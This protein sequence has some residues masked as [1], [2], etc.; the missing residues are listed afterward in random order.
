MTIFLTP[1]EKRSLRRMLRAVEVDR[2]GFWLSVLLGVVGMGSSIALAA[3]SAWLIAR[4]SQLPPVLYLSVAATSVRMFGVLRALMRYLQRLA[5]HKVALKGMDSLRF[6]VYSSLADARVDRVASM[7]RGDL[8]ARTGADIDAVGD[9]V[10]KAILPAMITG[11]VS[12]GTVGGIALISPATG[13][14]LAV[15]LIA[16]GI[17]APLVTMR[18][19]RLA[20]TNARDARVQ[21]SGGVVS[22]LEGASELG[23]NGRLD[24]VKRDI[25]AAETAIISST[26]KAARVSAIAVFVDRFAMGAA[27]VGAML[28][29]IPHTY[30]GTI[31]A[32]LLAVIVLTPL[33]SFEGTAEMAPA[34]VQLV[35]SA[36]ASERIDALLGNDAPL[37]EHP[38]PVVARPRLEARNL[39][40]G[41]PGG[42]I[43]ARNI[44]LDFTVG[45]RLA[46]VGPSGV[47][48]TTLLLTLAGM[49]EPREGSVTLNGVDIWAG[50]RDQVTSQV[51]MTAEDAHVFA[52]TVLENMRVAHPDLDEG[53]AADLLRIV[54]LESWVATLPSGLETMLGSGATTVSGGERRRLLMA[55]ALAAPSALL[56][57]DEASEHLDPNTADTLMRALYE[58]AQDNQ[59][60]IAIVTHRLSAL[61]AANTVIVLGKTTHESPAEIIASGRHTDLMA[62]SDTYR[63]AVE[64]ERA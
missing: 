46:I 63:W 40:V 43:V 35:R 57:A 7:K 5:S 22:F 42:P 30:G 52:T 54:G 20:E 49:L 11:I 64:Q 3:T 38:I 18:A 31:A 60:G 2:R 14:V 44:N 45:D 16:S 32:V 41:W 27:V 13:L 53:Q 15:C 47:G 55:R 17:I 39:A 48:K 19:A 34:A 28:I 6:H 37:K 10:V 1:N 9:L 21:L 56:M 36:Q 51:T 58:Q 8:L 26:A 62:S 25:Q 33:A 29:G 59:R 4:A 50:R 12:V 23:V 61:D 24:A